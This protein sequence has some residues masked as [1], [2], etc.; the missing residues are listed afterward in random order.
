MLS[1]VFDAV[2]DVVA[3]ISILCTNQ[4]LAAGLAKSVERSTADRKVAG[5]IP[6]AG[7]ILWVLK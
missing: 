5:P 1:E 2:G 3:C 6:G 4:N 7:P